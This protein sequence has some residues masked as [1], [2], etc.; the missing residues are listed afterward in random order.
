M[1]DLRYWIKKLAIFTKDLKCTKSSCIISFVKMSRYSQDIY[2]LQEE[3]TRFCLR[4]LTN[5]V[6]KVS[7]HFEPKKLYNKNRQNSQEVLNYIKSSC[8]I[9]SANS[10]DI[11][12]FIYCLQEES[13]KFGVKD[14]LTISSLRV[15]KCPNTP[16]LYT[17]DAH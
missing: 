9:I 1:L 12:K 13:T 3:L 7:R 16:I 15:P 6:Q 11:P 2:F 5:F 10:P 8:V 14:F 4:A 17:T